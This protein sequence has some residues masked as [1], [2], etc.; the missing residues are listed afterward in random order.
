MRY[1]GSGDFSPTQSLLAQESVCLFITC[2]SLDSKNIH[3]C[4]LNAGLKSPLPR[5]GGKV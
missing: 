4:N 1:V 3:L 2:A 5:S